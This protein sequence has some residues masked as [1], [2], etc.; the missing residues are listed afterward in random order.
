MLTNSATS[1]HR[2]SV[3]LCS[4]AWC[5]DPLEA[6]SGQPILCIIK[7]HPVSR[8]PGPLMGVKAVTWKPWASPRCGDGMH[9]SQSETRGSPVPANS[10]N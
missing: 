10:P 2:S 9:L 3:S 8:K 5:A 1:Q 6:V 7:G 4:S